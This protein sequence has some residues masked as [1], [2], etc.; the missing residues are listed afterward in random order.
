RFHVWAAGFMMRDRSDKNFVPGAVYRFCSILPSFY[1]KTEISV[2]N[3][4]VDNRAAAFQS[5][6][7]RRKQTMKT[8]TAGA[9]LLGLVLVVGRHQVQMRSAEPVAGESRGAEVQRPETFIPGLRTP[10]TTPHSL[11]SAAA[12]RGRPLRSTH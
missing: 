10:V 8:R 4:F 3:S 1:A 2:I 7:F 6:T 5:P 9:L 11:I 12:L